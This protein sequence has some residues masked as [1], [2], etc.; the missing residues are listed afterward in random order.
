MQM[1]NST[2]TSEQTMIV[3]CDFDNILLINAYAG[4]G[5]TSTL[6]KFCEKRA[7]YKILYLSYNSS[8]RAEAEVKFKHLKN[9]SVKTMHSL[10]YEKANKSI[11][12]RLGSLRA[13][14]LKDFISEMKESVRIFY[15]RALLSLIKQFC[16][17]GLDLKEFLIK[18][19]Q[20]PQKFGVGSHMD[21]SYI[22]NKFIALWQSEIP[23]NAKL[24]YEHDFYLKEFQLSK[25]E[26]DYD[27]VLVDEAQDING[28]V[29]D[30]VL[31]Q[32]CKKVFIGDTYQ[33]IYKF[34]GACNSLDIL[35]EI[36]NVKVLYLTQSFRCPLSIA[37]IANNYL[38]VLGAEK[39]FKGTSKE[40]ALDFEGKLK[41]NQ[42][43]IITRTNAKLF[44]IAVQNLDKKLFLVG[45][46]ESYNFN[47]LLD[48][49]NL[50]YK[51]KEYIK[52]E[53]IA[54]FDNVKELIA[55]SDESNE[56]DL[57]QRLLICFKYMQFNIFDLIKQIKACVVK[58]QENAELILSTGHKSKGLEWDKVEITDDFISLKEV[59]EN[60]EGN[61]EIAKEELNLF[62]VALT[63]SKNQL[64]L[65]QS[66]LIDN[67]LLKE[68]KKRI[69]VA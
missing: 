54:K 20:E 31:S 50:L 45:G 11:K 32:Q 17:T 64:I 38:K 35:S 4:T 56:I 19:L 53:F 9:V 13:L 49:Q 8:M 66:Y 62:Y 47:D 42:K 69:A 27:F 30:I 26:L 60:A 29:I 52:N 2:L 41:D 23:S 65:N 36:D 3:D 63:R 7:K 33:S 14:D 55:Y 34:R 67:A 5:K 22:G 6:I 51:K 43:A 18:F 48:I 25:P 15:A 46:I 37:G 39:D 40:V 44:D 61:I 24:A 16:N 28:C 68:C 58:K 21:I 10:A 59:L 57:K 1:S 12:D